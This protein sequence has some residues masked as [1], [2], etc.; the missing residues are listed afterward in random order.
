MGF[1]GQSCQP[2]TRL[3]ADTPLFKLPRDLV[4]VLD[5]DLVAAGIAGGMIAPG[6][7]KIDKRA[8]KGPRLTFM[9]YGIPSAP[10]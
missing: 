10:T 3:P 9:P 8:E 2:M 4:R 5:K 7:W 1:Q 6:K